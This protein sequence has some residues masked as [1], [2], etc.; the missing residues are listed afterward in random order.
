MPR[1]LVQASVLAAALDLDLC[2]RA[3]T[4]LAAALPISISIANAAIVSVQAWP[5]LH[6]QHR[7]ASVR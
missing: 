5:V 7:H 1:Q 2:R 3:V 4:G 6:H